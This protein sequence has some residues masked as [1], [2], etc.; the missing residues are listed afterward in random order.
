MRRVRGLVQL[1]PSS[2]R[3]VEEEEAIEVP[4]PFKRRVDVSTVL[5]EVIRGC[6][7]P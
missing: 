2:E 4:E 1:E 7:G 6:N 3:E 5:A